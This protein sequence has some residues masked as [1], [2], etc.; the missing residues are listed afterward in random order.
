MTS[1]QRVNPVEQDDDDD[2]HTSSG[3]RNPPPFSGDNYETWATELSI[4]KKV[5]KTKEDQW[6]ALIVASINK[7]KDRPLR[8]RIVTKL[9]EEIAGA[10][11]CKKVTDFLDLEFKKDASV[12]MCEKIDAWMTFTKTPD[13]S[14]KSFITGFE[15]AYQVAINAKLPAMPDAF[16]MY[17]LLKKANLSEH[18]HRMV[19]ADV[20]LTGT[21][22]FET[23]KQTLIK[24]FSTHV[25]PKSDSD[26]ITCQDT[27][28]GFRPR[29]G[30]IPRA[31][32]RPQLPP[33]FQPRPQPRPTGSWVN[34]NTKA[35]FNIP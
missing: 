7:K 26:Q 8:N 23:A 10:G 15:G 4:W 30:F 6:G 18:D 29:P 25:K 14:M 32:F 31:P 9:G 3:T 22:M 19:L 28:Y 1:P 20:D 11:G 34:P 13:M 5:T 35:G 33:R 27:F 21:T 16:L 2:Y 24:L 12:S 17:L